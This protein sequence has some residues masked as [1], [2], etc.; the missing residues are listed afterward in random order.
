M[1]TTNCKELAGIDCT[2]PLSGNSP[3]ELQQNVFAHAQL[4]HADMIKKM[5]PADQAKIVQRIKEVYTQKA[6]ASAPR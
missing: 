1:V 2:L 4:D 6:G 5:T 3:Q